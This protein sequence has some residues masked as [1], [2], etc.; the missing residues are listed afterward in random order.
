MPSLLTESGE[1]VRKSKILAAVLVVML[2]AGCAAKSRTKRTADSP[3]FA[4]YTGPVC[5][6]SIPLPPEVEATPVGKLVGSKR[7]YG[8]TTEVL[9]VAADEARRSGANLVVN[10]KSGHRVGAIAWARPL[11]SGDSYRLNDGETIDCAKYGG[12]LR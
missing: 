5:F 11:A 8:G 1:N 10:V 9:Q 4:R 12:T 3:E 2:M 7:W 6:L